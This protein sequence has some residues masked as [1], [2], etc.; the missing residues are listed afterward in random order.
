MN[1]VNKHIERKLQR[2]LIPYTEILR[3]DLVLNTRIQ[4]KELYK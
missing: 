4:L 1:S 2:E 3:R